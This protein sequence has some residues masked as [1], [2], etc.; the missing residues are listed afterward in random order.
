MLFFKKFLST[1]NYILN[2]R[3]G[4]NNCY[5]MPSNNQLV[6]ASVIGKYIQD[7]LYT[8]IDAKL[9]QMR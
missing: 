5:K 6:S 2:N 7:D 1:L 3:F 8:K 9:T 4:H